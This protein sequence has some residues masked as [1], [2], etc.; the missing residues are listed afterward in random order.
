MPLT[1]LA[2]CATVALT[3]TEQAD[4]L[5]RDSAPAHSTAQI[6]CLQ[7]LLALSKTNIAVESEEICECDGHTVHELS[8]RRLA[9]D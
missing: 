5:H 4:Q 1:E 2:Y 9:A 8:Q 6:G 7:Q 3:V